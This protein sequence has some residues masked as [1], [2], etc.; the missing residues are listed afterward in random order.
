MSTVKL[1]ALFAENKTGQLARVTGLLAEANV[2]IR[3]VTI[4][5]TEKFGVIKILLDDPEIGFRQLKHNGV[6]VSIVEALAI[7]VA[8]KP[9]GL[10]AVAQCLAQNKINV[11][12][13]SGL[14]LKDRA[15]LL[16]EAADPVL[17]ASLLQSQGLRL[18]SP[19]ELKG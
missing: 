2:N 13:A 11:E 10:F 1:L 16:I 12:N 9:G 7:E 17:A 8:D 15:V 5:G 3:W 4:A 6:P 14:I 18:L 19:Q